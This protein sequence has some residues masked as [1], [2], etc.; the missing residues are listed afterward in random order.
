MWN[1]LPWLGI[2]QRWDSPKD[3]IRFEKHGDILTYVEPSLPLPINALPQSYPVLAHSSEI[4]LATSSPLN[5]TLLNQLQVQVRQLQSPWAG[6]HFCLNS[7]IETGELGYNFAP[8]L[9]DVTL[10][11]TIRNIET[12]KEAY[13]C[14][15][16]IEEGP[17]YH[18]WNSKWDDLGF[19]LEAAQ[20]TNSAII[21]DIGH[22]YCSARNLG[23]TP[24]AGLSQ[25]VLKRV[26]EIHITGIGEHRTPGFYHDNHAAKVDEECWK[27]LEWSLNHTPHLKAITLEHNHGVSPDDYAQDL[28]RLAELVDAV[29]NKS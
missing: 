28:N 15:L 23:K 25:D 20:A 16:A 26:V 17:R 4:P 14:L 29:R 5:K 27:L 8:I 2:G 9:D 11:D 24:T 12:V 1:H 10:A 3:S 7:S 13:G 19:M 18:A 21:L 6:E 22:H